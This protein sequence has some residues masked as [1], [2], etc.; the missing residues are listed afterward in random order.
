MQHHATRYGI[1]Y[2]VLGMR[3]IGL[4][5]TRTHECDAPGVSRS[6]PD[7]TPARDRA[8][9]RRDGD[10]MVPSY[11]PHHMIPPFSPTGQGRHCLGTSSASAWLRSLEI[12]AFGRR[13]V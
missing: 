9:C 4:A 6:E 1:T 7:P 12:R 2:H 8:P 5:G 3:S 13:S 10:L 11:L